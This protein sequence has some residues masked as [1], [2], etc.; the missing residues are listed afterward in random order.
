MKTIEKYVFA[1][2][3]T[4]FLLAFLVLSFVLTIGLLVQ[5][6]GYIL[7]GVAASLV[8]D[9]AVVSFPETMQ[10]TIPLALL[11]SS[12][13]VFSR[14][15]ADSEI[16]AM[17]A[18]GINLWA[19]VK[20][21][22]GFALCCT[23]LGMC[24]NNEVVPRGHEVRRNLKA[25]VSVGAGLSVLQ[26][27]VWIDDFPK[28]KIYFGRKD[29]YT[30]HDLIV[31][32]NS[33]KSVDRLIRANKAIVSEQGRDIALDLFGMTVDPLDENHPGIARVNRYKYVMKDALK[34]S[35]YS[36]KTKDFNFSELTK[37]ISDTKSEEERSAKRLNAMLANGLEQ[38]EKSAIEEMR[39][40]R[41]KMKVELS[42]R[43]VFAMASL[44][45]VLAGIPLGIRA[46]RKESSIGMAISL[47]IA[48]GYYLLALVVISFQKT[49]CIYPEILIWLPVVICF[50]LG[51]RLVRKHL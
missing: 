2:F 42:K 39:R 41:S 38:E 37:A 12:V 40:N 3:L 1:S 7:D 4:S 27:G 29:G 19:V 44:C 50:A 15:S 46:Q 32:D 6:V 47:A 43:L 26:P 30:L 23:L 35:T 21:P 48:I 20:W 34:K 5:I 36:K 10:W 14:L 28:V 11:V 25:S 31:I 16:A 33:S 18:C 45:F 51:V 8:W 49:Y 22:V 13:L 24:L 17:R 9:F